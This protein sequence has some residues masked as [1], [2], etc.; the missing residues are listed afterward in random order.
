MICM[1]NKNG[2]IGVWLIGA[3]GAL[4]TTVAVGALAVVR[5]FAERTALVSDDPAFSALGLPELADFRFGGHEI[6]L[7]RLA[8]AARAIA[9]ENQSLR[10]DWIDAL[11]SDLAAIDADIRPGA[12]A[13]GGGAI[14]RIATADHVLHGG[15]ARELV[16]ALTRDLEQFRAKHAARALIVVNLASTEPPPAALPALETVADLERALDGSPEDVRPGALYAC[17]ALRAG[18][19]F[20]N[21]TPSASSLCGAIRALATQLRL[22]W[23]GNDGKTGETL[24]KSG[25]APMFRARCL[26]VMSWV[27]YNILGNRDGSVL[28]DDANKQSKL[29]SKDRVV[30]SILGQPVKTRV[31]IDYVESLG[32]NKVA[33]DYIHFRGF[34]GHPMAMQF[35]WQG[36]DSILAAPLVLDLVRF[37]TLALERGESGPMDHLAAFFKS[38][39]GVDEHDLYRQMAALSAYARSTAR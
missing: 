27:G 39:V 10:P 22:P 6:R 38:P 34:L 5:G 9:A 30:A 19:A 13:G 36:C 26:K 24:V 2:P 32:D 14:H 7:V 35:T 17:A 29:A 4:S 11:E 25:L 23:M 8:A 31:G 18:A 21:F 20:I 15:T 33:W 12:A 16:T 3:G 1:A 37:A 28:A